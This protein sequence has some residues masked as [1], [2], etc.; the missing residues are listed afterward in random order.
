MKTKRKTKRP[1]N[2]NNP[3][4]EELGLDP[5][6]YDAAGNPI[7]WIDEKTGA[8]MGGDPIGFAMADE[9]VQVIG[10]PSKMMR[11]KKPK[12]RAM[13]LEDIED[14]CPVCQANR[15]RILAGDPPMAYVYE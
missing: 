6:L 5:D 12:Y 13:R 9:S 4:I 10:D 3:W 2:P 11:G 1:K 15:E 8:L 14:D 7:E